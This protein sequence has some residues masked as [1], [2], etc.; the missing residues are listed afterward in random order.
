M[1]DSTPRRTSER[2]RAPKKI[3]RLA[4]T[5][6]ASWSTLQLADGDPNKAGVENILKICES[7][8]RREAAARA[9]LLE[10]RAE[11]M[12]RA[13]EAL[14]A[15]AEAAKAGAPK[16]AKTGAK[17]GAKDAAPAAAAS[18]GAEGA[19]EAEEAAEATA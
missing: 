1:S 5:T 4:R 11:K 16:A 10:A 3:L 9:A 13:A 14:R 15:S 2:S 7:I 8:E 6:A 12:Q 18:E 19:E 17:T